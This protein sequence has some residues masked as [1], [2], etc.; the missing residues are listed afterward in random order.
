MDS[1]QMLSRF[2][3]VLSVLKTIKQK[4]KKEKK[5]KKQKTKDRNKMGYVNTMNIE[6]IS[7]FWNCFISYTA[8][9]FFIFFEV[10]RGL[11]VIWNK[12]LRKKCPNI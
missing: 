2:K 3:E 8:M 10:T 11:S 6:S 4:K 1:R 12:S 5:N 9:L 7:R